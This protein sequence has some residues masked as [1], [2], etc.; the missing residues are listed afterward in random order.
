MFWL[1]SSLAVTAA[2]PCLL[3]PP[4]EALQQLTAAEGMMQSRIAT[5]EEAVRH[6]EAMKEALRTD[7]QLTRRLA[8]RDLR[9][10]DPG[11]IRFVSTRHAVHSDRSARSAAPPPRI[12]DWVA[13]LHPGRWAVAYRH[14]LSR[15]AVLLLALAVLTFAVCTYGPRR[16]FKPRP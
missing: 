16:N 8:M 6:Q 14:S 7:P 5:L 11:E 4:I 3:V 9:Y 13:R 10:G 12:P 15:H 1:L 2:A